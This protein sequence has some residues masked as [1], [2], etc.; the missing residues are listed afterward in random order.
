MIAA[1]RDVGA[2]CNKRIITLQERSLCQSRR[3]GGYS[4]RANVARLSKKFPYK[5]LINNF[6]Q[7]HV[8][9]TFLRIIRT[10]D[11]ALKGL[12]AVEP[13]VTNVSESWSEHREQTLY[14]GRAELE[15]SA[16]TVTI[17]WC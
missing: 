6:A 2:P 11:S 7:C 5:S 3:I 4:S 12:C 16:Y 13:P 1:A 14:G 8:D 15:G 17:V 10:G 9:F